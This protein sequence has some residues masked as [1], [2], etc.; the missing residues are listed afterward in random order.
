M[1]AAEDKR[2]HERSSDEVLRE[3]DEV[4]GRVDSEEDRQGFTG[5]ESFFGCE[6]G[7]RG[8]LG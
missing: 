2:A 1:Y 8:E 7:R 4:E 6:G 5:F 3:G